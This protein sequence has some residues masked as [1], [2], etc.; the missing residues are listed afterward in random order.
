M[1][2]EDAEHL[3]SYGVSTEPVCWLQSGYPSGYTTKLFGKPVIFRETECMGTGA[4][5]CAIVGQ[6]A[7]AW[8]KDAPEREYFGL[9]WRQRRSYGV[10]DAPV[11]GVEDL[12][13]STDER[14]T[15]VGVSAAVIRTRRLLERSDGRDRPLHGRIRVGKEL[16]STQLHAL[17]CR[18]DKPFVA[19]NCAAIPETLI[20]AELFGVEKGAFTGATISRSGYFERAAGGTLFL[21]EFSSL[22]YVAQGKVLRALQEHTIERVGGSKTILVDVRVVAACNVDL[23]AEVASG[24]FRQDLYFRLCVFPILIPPLRERRDDIPLLMAHFLEFYS[25]RH[26]RK[27]KGFTRRATDALL[28][29]DYPGNIRE[30]QNLIERGVVYADDGGQIDVVHL[31]VAELIPPFTISLAADGRLARANPWAS[32]SL[33]HRTPVSPKP[34]FRPALRSK[35]PSAPLIF[36][37]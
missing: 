5:R 8:G 31:F 7:D 18:A 9:E 16:F 28:K 3:S 6:H 34:Q 10:R 17:S 14:S 37:P 11:G 27:L 12:P 35:K 20:E 22:T 13:R 36:P 21:D 32:K 30:L 23:A 33:A 29:Y 19:I 26:A 1:I 15:V 25:Q 24:R 2:C 4:K